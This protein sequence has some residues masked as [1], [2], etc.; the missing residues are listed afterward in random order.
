[1]LGIEPDLI[2]VAKGLTSAYVPL[3]ACIVSER[4]WQRPRRRG[5][6]ASAFGHGYTYTSHPL[7]AACALAN[8]ELI[9][10]D[11]LIEQAAARG[12]RLSTDCS[13]AFRDHPLVGEVRGRGLIAAVEFTAGRD[14]RGAS[15]RSA[16]SARGSTPS[17]SRA[18]SSPASCP[19]P[20]RSRSR[21][22][23]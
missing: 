14:P 11:G 13:D 2:T 17:A 5:R 15:T 6:R 19:T 21:R 16:A 7:A 3:S 9:E 10:R 1:M 23:S 8:L 4:V 20:T 18:A 12:E 22:R